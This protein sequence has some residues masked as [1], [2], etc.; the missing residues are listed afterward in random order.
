MD[1]E[2]VEPSMFC[3][4]SYP[5][6]DEYDGGGS[7]LNEYTT[8]KNIL[9]ECGGRYIDFIEIVKLI[10]AGNEVLI[11][12]GEIKAVGRRSGN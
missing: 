7:L 4:K 2:R 10:R 8:I 3:L 9:S 12:S 1:S 6:F 11:L 5:T